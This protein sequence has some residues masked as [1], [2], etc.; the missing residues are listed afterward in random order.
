MKKNQ[1]TC[2]TLKEKILYVFMFLCMLI[3]AAIV[4]IVIGYILMKGLPYITPEF[5]TSS[6][7]PGLDEYGIAPMIVTTLLVVLVTIVIAVPLGV[8]AAVYLHEYSPKGK[9][10]EW[11]RFATKCLTGIPSILYGLFGFTLFVTMLNFNYTVLSGALTLAIMVLPIIMATTEEALQ[12]VPNSL[13]E[14]SYALGAGKLTTI[15]RAVLPSAIGGILTGTVL[16]IG[17]IVGETAVVIYTVGTAV[18]G[19]NGLLSPGRTLAVH[20][21]MLTKEGVELSQAFAAATVL[22]I[23]VLCING[24]AGWIARR[25]SPRARAER[26]LKMEKK[27]R[28]KEAKN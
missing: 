10:V 19:I 15:F 7:R 21:Y 13:R 2:A 18:G 1:F 24:F 14:A 6:Y 28:A 22:L 23:L 26:E 3:T 12:S 11:I 16:A 20:V 17:R 4:V 8:G 5:L 27:E 9:W 25:L